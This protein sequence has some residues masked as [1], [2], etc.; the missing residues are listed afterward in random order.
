MRR[1]LA[2]VLV[3]LLSTTACGGKDAKDSKPKDA[4]TTEQGA[5]QC[6][7][8]VK[9]SAIEKLADGPVGP[10][11]QTDIGGLDACKWTGT[12]NPALTVTVVRTPAGVWV[13]KLPPLIDQYEQT[14]ALKGADAQKIKRAKQIINAAGI[15]DGKTACNIFTT[16][17]VELQKMPAGSTETVNWLPNQA[18]P[19][20]INIQTCKDGTYTSMQLIAPG[21]TGKDGDINRI[22]A[23]YDALTPLQQ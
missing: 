10:P 12:R 22:R 1:L 6:L 15:P 14:G 23:A 2:T 9:G 8:L 13:E 18:K 17:L 4:P 16:M 3:V 5:A 21:L 7:H 11:E 19:Q 20:A